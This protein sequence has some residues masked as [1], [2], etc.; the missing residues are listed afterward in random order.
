MSILKVNTIT[1]I[2]DMPKNV[3][4]NGGLLGVNFT[5]DS[6]GA[7]PDSTSGDSFR[8]SAGDWFW[9]SGN[10]TLKLYLNDSHGWKNIGLTDSSGVAPASSFFLANASRLVMWGGLQSGGIASNILDYVAIDTPGNATDFGDDI[11]PARLNSCA[12]DGTTGVRMGGIS[13]A[14]TLN[15]ISYVTIATAGNAVSWGTFTNN[16]YSGSGFGDG[17]Y[18]YNAGGTGPEGGANTSIDYFTLATASNASDFGD[19]ISSNSSGNGCAAC[20]GTEAIIHIG[21]S[22]TLEYITPGVSGVTASD[23]GDLYIDGQTQK[24]NSTAVAN[25]TY[26]VTAGGDNFYTT[27]IEY[28]TFGSPGNATDF[29]DITVHA[30]G[31][32]GMGGSSNQTYGVIAGGI[33][34][35][36]YYNVIEYITIDTPSNATDFGDMT[37]TRTC[38]AAAG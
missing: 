5:V 20:N 4:I 17:T 37:V 14:A 15:T 18:A 11:S 7:L 13:N 2:I 33:Y 8:P 27:S 22:N 31:R 16:R 26:W 38:D 35:G 21:Y 34:S 1:G 3:R 29:G 19:T 23:F 12:S 32:Y 9:D 28:V 24:A 36:T 30:N 6:L 10:T 25:D